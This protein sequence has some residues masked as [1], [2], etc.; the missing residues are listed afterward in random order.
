MWPGPGEMRIGSTRFSSGPTLTRT[1][2]SSPER[3]PA[4]V[5]RRSGLQRLLGPFTTVDYPAELPMDGFVGF[6]E[7]VQ[8][9][10]Q[11]SDLVEDVR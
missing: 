7:D 11:E 3:V 9:T 4:G 6:M 2:A 1:S 8:S 5:L 10:A